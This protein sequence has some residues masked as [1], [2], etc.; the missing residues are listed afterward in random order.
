M[1]IKKTASLTAGLALAAT[2]LAYA[3]KASAGACYMYS[4][5]WTQEQDCPGTSAPL[6]KT[7]GSNTT[8]IGG[9]PFHIKSLY[10]WFLG[11]QG[12]SAGAIALDSSG[13]AISGCQ[14]TDYG[15]AD[16]YPNFTAAVACGGGAT[17]YTQIGW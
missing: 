2:L 3:P 11:A 16:L 13:H 14:V 4:S 15:P 7:W 9:I 6:G 10:A 5:S 12:G 1:T 8:R 17:F